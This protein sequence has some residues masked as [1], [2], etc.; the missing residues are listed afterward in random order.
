[1]TEMKLWDASIGDKVR[2]MNPTFGYEDSGC[3]AGSFLMENLPRQS[4]L[5]V[6][7]GTTV[8]ACLV[9][10][11]LSHTRRT[12]GLQTEKATRAT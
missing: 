6:S 5:P 9:G 7:A 8:L 3:G 1:M 10:E 11:T 12:D 4:A 2:L